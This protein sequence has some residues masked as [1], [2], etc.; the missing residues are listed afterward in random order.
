LF[1]I[2]PWS[3]G[4]VD[5]QEIDDGYCVYDIPSVIFQARELEP[6]DMPLIGMNM[7]YKVSNGD[8][9]ID[10]VS[11]M[12][13]VLAADLTKPIILDRDG[14]LIDGRHRICKALLE[15]HQTIKAVRFAENPH[16]KRLSEK[17]E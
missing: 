12:K 8:Y 17:K 7:A 16:Y 5:S 11:H 9:L 10:F 15:G 3:E 1:E 14:W 13:S 2:K 4:K 6:F